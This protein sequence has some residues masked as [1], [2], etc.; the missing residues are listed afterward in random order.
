MREVE[1]EI[2]D[3]EGKDKKLR[4]ERRFCFDLQKNK[5]GRGEGGRNKNEK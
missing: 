5:G 1:G 4:D 3:G 2:E